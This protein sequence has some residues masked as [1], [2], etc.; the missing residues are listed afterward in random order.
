MNQN[1]H[2][3]NSY[4]EATNIAYK[5][6]ETIKLKVNKELKFKNLYYKHWIILKLIYFKEAKTSSEIANLICINKS[7]LSRLI[8]FMEEMSLITR[9][10]NK[11][12]RRQIILALTDQGKDMFSLGYEAFLNVPKVFE[13]N[14]HDTIDPLVDLKSQPLYTHT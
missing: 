9:S 8:D 5:L 13:E 4:L 10:K 3:L 12:D 1:A 14:E 2:Q 6:V 7:S 11:Y